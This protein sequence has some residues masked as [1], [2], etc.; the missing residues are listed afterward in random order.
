[1][2]VRTAAPSDIPGVQ[3]VARLAW[4]DTYQHLLPHPLIAHFLTHA[5]STQALERTLACC[6]DLFVVAETQGA[7]VGFAHFGPIAPRV[8]ELFR[9]YVLPAHQ[10][11]GAGKALLEAG[12]SWAC[13]R[14]L[15]RLEVSVL[16]GNTK[17]SAFY[18]RHGFTLQQAQRVVV[19]GEGVPLLRY[20]RLV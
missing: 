20:A 11:A 17:G 1:M 14:G 6:M 9:I 13:A 19:R 3:K 7:V 18:E 4:W 8:A 10:G 15:A 16:R 2:R 5:Y 12:L